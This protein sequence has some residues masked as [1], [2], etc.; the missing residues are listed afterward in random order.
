VRAAVATRTVTKPV[1]AAGHYLVVLK[2][3]ARTHVESVTVY[4]SGASKRTV[5]VNSRSAV[6]LDYHLTVAR[7]PAKLTARAVSPQ[8]T[9]DLAM[10]LKQQLANKPATPPA[11]PAAPTAP[12]APAPVLYPN[13]YQN[14]TPVF[15]DEFNGSAGSAPSS[16]WNVATNDGQCGSS[17][18]TNTTSAAN[19]SLNGQGQLAITALHNGSGGYP[20]T[21]AQISTTLPNGPYGSVEASI[22]LP[23]GQGLC[24][25]F[26][27]NGEPSWPNDGEIDILEA[28]TFGPL[29]DEAFFTLHGPINPDTDNGNYQQFETDTFAPGNLSAG[30]HTYGIVWTPNLIVWT[31]DGVEYASATPSS[32]VAGSTWVFNASRAYQ[33]ILDLAVGGWPGNPTAATAFPAQMLV[34]WVRVYQ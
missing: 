30:F 32:L 34:D 7:A 9:V 12:A 23:P 18:N 28:P 27:L 11:P 4:L 25:A 14:T 16:S 24:G 26:W 2:V 17:I 8:P 21:S 19:V 3:R 29:P 15:D 5:R 13:P 31:I 10:T 22:K 20:Y 6:A 33:L 1:K